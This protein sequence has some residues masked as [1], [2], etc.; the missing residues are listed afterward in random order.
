MN[1]YHLLQTLSSC[2][3]QVLKELEVKK[4]YFAVS[5]IVIA[6]QRHRVIKDPIIWHISSF[7][8]NMW[9]QDSNMIVQMLTKCPWK[10]RSS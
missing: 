4:T 9:E 5:S 8:C 2:F 6:A 10:L 3:F 1:E 7:Y